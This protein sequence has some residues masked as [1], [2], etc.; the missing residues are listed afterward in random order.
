M[1]KVSQHDLSGTFEASNRL[2]FLLVFC[3]TKKKNIKLK[4][5]FSSESTAAQ[6]YSLVYG[7]WSKNNLNL[8]KKI[9]N[10][11][12]PGWSMHLHI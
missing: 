10:H 8:R 1:D 9:K 4:N 12:I 11:A 2:L 5:M 6:N 3:K 7:P